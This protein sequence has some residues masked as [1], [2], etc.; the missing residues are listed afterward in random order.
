MHRLTAFYTY[1][2]L[3]EFT[4]RCSRLKGLKFVLHHDTRTSKVRQ[5]S[6][7]HGVSNW[8]T[9]SLPFPK[10]PDAAIERRIPTSVRLAAYSRNSGTLKP[11]LRTFHLV[12][13]D[14]REP[15]PAVE[16]QFR[17]QEIEG[18][19]I[20]SNEYDKQKLLT[21]TLWCTTLLKSM[22]QQIRP[23]I[24]YPQYRHT[25]SPPTHSSASQACI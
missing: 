14:P 24:P 19:G 8:G 15:I 5:T 23:K 25:T 10:T 11:C 21:L 12:F 7:N 17:F 3:R 1:I 6:A 9:T 16:S 4:H 22:A 18:N 20:V 13:T 2:G